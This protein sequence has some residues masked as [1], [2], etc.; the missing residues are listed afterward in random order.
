MARVARETPPATANDA[1]E[2][3]VQASRDTLSSL[4]TA[5]LNLT[6]VRSDEELINKVTTQAQSV[7]TTLQSKVAELTK[8][9][10]FLVQ[11][12]VYSSHFHLSF[13]LFLSKKSRPK[14]MPANS[15]MFTNNSPI[16]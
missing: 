11:F 10:N 16:D 13:Y 9:V 8:E 4:H 7:G 15:R 6:G 14:E 5:I 1:W 12:L 2:D 3:V